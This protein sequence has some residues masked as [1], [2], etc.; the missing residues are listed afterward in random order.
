MSTG[1]GPSFPCLMELDFVVI[2]RTFSNYRHREGQMGIRFHNSTFS[3][4]VLKCVMHKYYEY[5]I[6]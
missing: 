6:K 3:R 5:Y 2:V 1:R 4:K